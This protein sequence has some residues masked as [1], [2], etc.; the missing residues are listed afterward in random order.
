VLAAARLLDG[1]RRG[2]RPVFCCRFS[3]ALVLLSRDRGGGGGPERLRWCLKNL[4]REAAG[5]GRG[6]N[7]MLG[8]LNAILLL[9]VRVVP[10]AATLVGASLLLPVLKRRAVVFLCPVCEGTP[11]TLGA[12]SFDR[13][14]LE[15]LRSWSLKVGARRG[16][17]LRWCPVPLPAEDLSEFG[18]NLLANSKNLTQKLW[19][20]RLRLLCASSSS[21]SSSLALRGSPL[22]RCRGLRLSQSPAWG[23]DVDER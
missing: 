20:P 18:S 14:S 8:G 7:V 5:R 4:R 15:G 9:V 19:R 23:L 13:Q 3:S 6:P 17:P 22:R 12:A 10:V 21:P 1:D 16:V 11:R 2:R